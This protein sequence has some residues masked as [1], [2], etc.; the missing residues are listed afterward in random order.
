MGFLP[1]SKKEYDYVVLM[2]DFLSKLKRYNSDNGNIY[3]F[4]FVPQIKGYEIIYY[5]S[6]NEYRIEIKRNILN[7]LSIKKYK[8]SVLK[9]I[10]IY[11]SHSPKDNEFIVNKI[12]E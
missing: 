11:S 12:M 3:D 4:K 10:Q 7:G 2:T 5:H 9:I 8:N 6:E 1:I